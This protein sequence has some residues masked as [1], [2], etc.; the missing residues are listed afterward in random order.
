[1]QGPVEVA[2]HAAA[3]RIWIVRRGAWQPRRWDERPPAC[4]PRVGPA[5]TDAFRADE[6]ARYIEG[7]NRA[8]LTASGPYWAV[9]VPL[10]DGP[11]RPRPPRRG[12]R[13]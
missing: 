11:R 9:A 7:F 12:R 13:N 10:V 8:M 3:V 6:A 1:M 4:R 2:R 5:E